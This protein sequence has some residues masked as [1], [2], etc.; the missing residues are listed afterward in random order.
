MSPSPPAPRFRYLF[1]I[2]SGRSGTRYLTDLLGADPRVDT[3]HEPDPK[4]HGAFLHRTER[5]GL[6]ATATLVLPR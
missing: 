3:S 4:I 1:T 2:A 6:A 5:E